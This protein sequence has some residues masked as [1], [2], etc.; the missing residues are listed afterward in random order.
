MG[1]GCQGISAALGRFYLHSPPSPAGRQPHGLPAPPRPL[2]PPALRDRSVRRRSRPQSPLC[3][4]QHLSQPCQP[5]DP[6][7]GRDRDRRADRPPYP[8]YAAPPAAP[9][10]MGTATL[11]RVKLGFS[12]PAAIRL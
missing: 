7:P 6:G 3:K 4:V 5:P 9:V 12:S 10:G 8:P 1:T 11:P 2:A